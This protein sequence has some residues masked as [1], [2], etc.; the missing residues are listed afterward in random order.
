MA[1]TKSAAGK[2]LYIWN[3]DW[4]KVTSRLS[5]KIHQGWMKEK[6]LGPCP[7][8]SLL[9]ERSKWVKLNSGIR[10]TVHWTSAP[11]KGIHS[12]HLKTWNLARHSLLWR[13]TSK[14]TDLKWSGQNPAA[15]KS[16]NWCRAE[17]YGGTM[18]AR[19]S[20]KCDQVREETIK[21]L[22]TIDKTL[23]PGKLKLW[24][25]Q[26]SREAGEDDQLIH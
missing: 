15:R 21:C 6:S 3:C 26:W 17:Q 13:R 20:D 24:C 7:D 4:S 1:L 9:S 11:Q 16:S 12:E 5:Q 19:D 25:L 8:Q 14:A 18:W 22:I 2:E 23:L 10:P